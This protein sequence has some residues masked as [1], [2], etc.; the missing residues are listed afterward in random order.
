MKTLKNEIKKNSQAKINEALPGVAKL[1]AL[2][3]PKRVPVLPIAFISAGVLTA[4][5]AIALPIALHNRSNSLS[6]NFVEQIP[7]VEVNNDN[8][9]NSV[10]PPAFV[11]LEEF[12]KPYDKYAFD[13]YYCEAENSYIRLYENGYFR[14]VNEVQKIVQPYSTDGELIIVYNN[15]IDGDPE[16]MAAHKVDYMIFNLNN[17]VIVSNSNLSVYNSSFTLNNKSFV[18]KRKEVAE[19]AKCRYTKSEANNLVVS[20]SANDTIDDVDAYL[21]EAE[22]SSYANYV[23][24]NHGKNIRFTFPLSDVN[25]NDTIATFINLN[26]NGAIK[27]TSIRFDDSSVIRTANIAAFELTDNDKVA[28]YEV[29]QEITISSSKAP[30]EDFNKGLCFET[31][32]AAMDYADSIRPIKPSSSENKDLINFI[33]SLSQEDFANKKLIVSNVVL[34]EDTTFDYDFKNMYL[35]DGELVIVLEKTHDPYAYGFQKLTYTVFAFMVDRNV[36]FDSI[37]TLF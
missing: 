28:N 37:V 31:Y 21:N 2:P 35:K 26:K 1:D 10:T 14:Y 23:S 19:N 25:A 7:V 6:N 27:N 18:L 34:T 11:P 33:E 13:E 5:V 29:K 9:P 16:D 30:K 32:Q 12:H 3:L 8:D 36:S 24:N 4:T 22:L 15:Y 17:D 20:Y